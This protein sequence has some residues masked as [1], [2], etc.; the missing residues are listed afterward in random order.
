M[1]KKQQKTKWLLEEFCV[2][3]NLSNMVTKKEING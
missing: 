1:I 2:L 3:E